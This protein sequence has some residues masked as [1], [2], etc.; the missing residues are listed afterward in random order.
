[1]GMLAMVLVF[2]FTVAGCGAFTD[3]NKIPNYL[4]LA[5]Q[6]GRSA[7]GPV[8][9]AVKVNLDDNWESLLSAINSLM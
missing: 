7:E 9:L 2:G 4:S 3:M 6:V 8:P 1:M 5:K